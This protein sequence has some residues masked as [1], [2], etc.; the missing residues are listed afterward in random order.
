MY[1][2]PISDTTAIAIDDEDEEDWL[3]H[4]V[5]FEAQTMETFSVVGLGSVQFAHYDPDRGLIWVLIDGTIFAIGIAEKQIF[6][7]SPPPRERFYIYS[8]ISGKSHLY[9]SGEY[10]NLWRISVHEQEWEPLLT[11]EPEPPETDDEE[12]QTRR[13]KAYAA[14][15]PDYYFG[16][17][18]GEDYI[19]CGGMGALAR[20]RGT[21]VEIQAIETGARLVTGR[22]EGAQISLSADSPGAEIYLGD[23]DA[24]FEV[25]FSDNQPSLH[26]TAIHEGRRYIGIAEYPPSD[27]HNLY[28]YEKDE[29]VPIETDCAREPLQLIS[30]SSMG[31]ALWAID[32]FGLFR[33]SDG[34]WTLVD[35]D[36]LQSGVWPEGG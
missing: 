31:S 28:V 3:V 30:L 26:R 11:P 20:V 32:A 15:Y 22:V 13:N 34:K 35:D 17:Q 14:K 21:S 18:V 23:F 6:D 5:D 33:L 16:F 2:L 7:I 29:L 9:I 12:E 10:S 8:M 19:F 1:S 25:V 36:D 27:L 4:F 24:G